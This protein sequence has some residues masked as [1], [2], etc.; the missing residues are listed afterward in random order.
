MCMGSRRLWANNVQTGTVRVDVHHYCFI[1]NDHSTSS[2][3]D[4]VTTRHPFTISS[5]LTCVFFSSLIFSLFFSLAPIFKSSRPWRAQDCFF[6]SIGLSDLAWCQ[7]GLR[8]TYRTSVA[9]PCSD[10]H[11]L[12]LPNKLQLLGHVIGVRVAHFSRMSSLQGVSPVH[13][14][15]PMAQPGAIQPP[16]VMRVPSKTKENFVLRQ[17]SVRARVG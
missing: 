12:N 3:I 4:S 1:I 9:C 6:Y 8:A 11:G 5:N 16:A 2:S 13:S 17:D 15:A 10:E 14:E 7:C